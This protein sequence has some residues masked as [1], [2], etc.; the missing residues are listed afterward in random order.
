MIRN[1]QLVVILPEHLA[2]VQVRVI[3]GA[4]SEELILAVED[5]AGAGG[6]EP[7]EKRHALTWQH[8]GYR[9]IALDDVQWIEAD[10]SYS[11]VHLTGGRTLTVSFNLSVVGKDLP[12][13]DFVRVHRSYVIHLKHMK[14]LTGNGVRVGDKLLPVGREYR[15]AFLSR[16]V[17][18]SVRKT[19][20]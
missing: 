5:A 11:I 12:D 2:D 20:I 13:R 10:G 17:F 16:F 6:A 19:K 8:D 18:L 15:E 7:S 4:G 3:K 9:K 1:K 14:S